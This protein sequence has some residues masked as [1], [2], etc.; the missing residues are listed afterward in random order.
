MKI[1]KEKQKTFHQFRRSRR[2]TAPST[3]TTRQRPVIS[4]VQHAGVLAT[5]EQLSELT[6]RMA[7]FIAQ[8]WLQDGDSR[9]IA[10]SAHLESDRARLGLTRS[11]ALHVR[12]QSEI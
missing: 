8:G 3:H 11:G 10:F 12:L 7:A 6:Q 9:Q 2:K 1:S 5:D 4:E